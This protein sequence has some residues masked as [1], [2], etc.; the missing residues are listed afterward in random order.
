MK[1]TPAGGIDEHVG[2]IFIDGQRCEVWVRSEPDG[3]GNWHN[4]LVFR[5]EGRAVGRS[6]RVTGVTWH[7]PPGIALQ[8]ARELGETE[9]LALFHRARDPR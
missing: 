5:R 8:R 7:V 1:S 3:D 2:A 4:A 6:V 9:Q